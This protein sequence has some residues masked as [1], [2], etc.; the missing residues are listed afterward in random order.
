MTVAWSVSSECAAAADRLGR[1]MRAERK[2]ETEREGARRAPACGGVGLPCGSAMRDEVVESRKIGMAMEVAKL[3]WLPKVA[4]CSLA[5]AVARAQGK[6]GRW[7][8]GTGRKDGSPLRMAERS[9]LL[10]D[11]ALTGKIA[12]SKCRELQLRRRSTAEAER[13]NEEVEKASCAISQV[14]RKAE[15]VSKIAEGWESCERLRSCEGCE[16][17][18]GWEGKQVWKGSSL[19]GAWVGG[20]DVGPERGPFVPSN[21]LDVPVCQLAS[22]FC[23]QVGRMPGHFPHCVGHGNHTNTKPSRRVE[24]GTC[25]SKE[26]A[27]QPSDSRVTTRSTQVGNL[28]PLLGDGRLPRGRLSG[29]GKRRGRTRGRTRGRMRDRTARSNC[30]LGRCSIRL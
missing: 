21:G 28:E 14:R 26:A 13:G 23:G 29:K 30:S 2:R 18:K 22:L 7:R 19:G 24:E 11:F 25:P 1:R 20:G 16:G 9:Y 6:D 15:K 10:S 3:R 4:S 27:R 17:W 5:R 8:I 12:E